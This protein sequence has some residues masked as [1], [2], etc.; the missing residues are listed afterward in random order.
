MKK[1]IHI[2]RY[3]DKLQNQMIRKS[4]SLISKL[5]ITR[6]QGR[7]LHFISLNEGKGVCNQREIEEYMNIRSSTATELLQKLENKN[8]IQRS[9]NKNDKRQKII[10]ITDQ[11]KEVEKLVYGKLCIL[12]EIISKDIDEKDIDLFLNLVNKMIDN[13]SE[14]KEVV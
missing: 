5:G 6:A 7:V 10:T 8:L 11:G 14:N 4:E 13:L 2:G 9:E 1:I 3:I 12:E